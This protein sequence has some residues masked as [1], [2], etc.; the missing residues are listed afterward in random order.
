MP[1]TLYVVEVAPAILS[2][3]D[4]VLDCHCKVC[5]VDPPVITAVSKELPPTQISAFCAEILAVGSCFTITDKAADAGSEQSGCVS[6]TWI[7]YQIVPATFVGALYVNAVAPEILVQLPVP[8]GL[9][10]HCTVKALEPPVTVAVSNALP[11]IHTSGLL[12]LMVTVALFCTMTV[13]IFEN[14]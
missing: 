13:T 6:V 1:C 11:S 10:C 3:V 9:D 4:P 12:T 2:Q 5:W 7:R 14:G 8:F